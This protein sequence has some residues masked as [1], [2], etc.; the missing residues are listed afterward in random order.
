MLRF[1]SVRLDTVASMHEANRLYDILGFH[2]IRPYCENLLPGARF[3][4]KS[5]TP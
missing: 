4:E 3:F 2:E 1:R 5:L